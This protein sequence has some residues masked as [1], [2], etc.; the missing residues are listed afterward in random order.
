[1]A[2]AAP[3]PGCPGPAGA[4]RGPMTAPLASGWRAVV[5]LSTALTGILTLVSALTPNVPERE[6]LLLEVE[7]GS[8]MS[9]GHVLAAVAGVG[10][11][12]L[13]GGLLRGRRRALDVTI[14]VLCVAALLHAV[15]GLDYEESLTTLALAVVLILGRRAF[16]LG[17]GS[18]A[19]LAAGA[20]AV[21]AVAG[22]YAIEMASVWVA[23]PRFSFLH[24]ASAALSGLASGGWWLRSDEP[25]AVACDLLLMVAMLAGA[26]WLHAVLSPT[27]ATD[28]HS[29][30]EHRRAAQIVARDGRDSLAPFVLREDKAFFFAHDGVLAYRTLGGTAVVSGDPVGPPGSAGP[31]VRDFLAHAASHGWDTVL[32][33]ASGEHLEAYATLGLRTLHIG[34]EAVVDPRG[35]SL[36]GRAIRKVRQSVHRVQRH[37]W[38]V[39]I[40]ASTDMAP[41]VAAEIE[42]VEDRWRGRRRRLQGFAMTLGRL[43]AVVPDADELFVVARAPDGE[44]RAFLRFSHHLDGLSLDVMRRL[45]DEPNG[46]NEAL[47]TAALLHAREAGVRA[48]SL[49]FAGLAHVMAADATLSGPQRVLRRL[50]GRFRGRF[51]LER[52]VRFNDKFAPQWRPRYL[53]YGSRTHLPLAGLRVLQAEAYLRAPRSRPRR[54]RWLPDRPLADGAGLTPRPQGS[55]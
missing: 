6:S 53:V 25:L 23:R 8:V 19:R 16:R 1:M 15:K 35:F 54:E 13:A 26:A 20:I 2:T 28:G 30:S 47:V 49:N 42:S 50:I 43:S 55:R 31:I 14:V 10:L 12:V 24:V 41:A 52:L 29:I 4:K 39:E 3:S 36:E 18:P 46:L 17:G 21:G 27:R 51:Q 33:G 11:I 45:D 32:T 9:L 40:H 44:L 34:N 38:R 5:A 37:G 7:P 22:M 48:V